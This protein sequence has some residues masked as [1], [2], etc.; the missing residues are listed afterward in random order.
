MTDIAKDD[1]D[2]YPPPESQ[3]G[4]RRADEPD[5]ARARAGVNLA[6]LAA[7]RA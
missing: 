3:G 5:A 4:W 2:Y 6:R 7:A 1:M